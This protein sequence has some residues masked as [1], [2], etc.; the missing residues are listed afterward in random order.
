M[1][2]AHTLQCRIDGPQGEG[3][4]SLQIT[5]RYGPNT[6]SLESQPR[7]CPCQPPTLVIWPSMEYGMEF[8][9]LASKCWVVKQPRD[10]VLLERH[11]SS[12]LACTPHSHILCDSEPC[13][14]SEPCSLSLHHMLA[15]GSAFCNRSVHA[16]LS[17]PHIY[18][19]D[20]AF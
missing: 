16:L 6:Q 20:G 9:R 15:L 13:Q 12:R 19:R 4:E 11:A 18:V 1:Y 3:S 5:G 10:W 7:H 17:L 14:G 8:P 2:R